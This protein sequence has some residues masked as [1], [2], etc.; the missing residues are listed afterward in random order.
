MSKAPTAGYSKNDITISRIAACVPHWVTYFYSRGIG[1][2]LVDVDLIEKFTGAKLPNFL[3]NKMIPSILPKIDGYE[4]ILTYCYVFSYMLDAIINPKNTATHDKVVNDIQTYVNAAFNST[5]IP[6]KMRVELMVNFGML[7]NN[8]KTHFN[9]QML[10]LGTGCSSMWRLICSSKDRK[11]AMATIQLRSSDQASIATSIE[12]QFEPQT[13]TLR[14]LDKTIENITHDHSPNI[15]R[16]VNLL[17]KK[18]KEI[19]FDEFIAA[20]DRKGSRNTMDYFMAKAGMELPE[21]SGAE[22]GQN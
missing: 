9:K 1:K 13:F 20:L 2:V 18:C 16:A 5:F 22:G 21:G 6:S 8:N 19:N 17:N 15:Q 10:S 14:F 12:D 3:K 7:E 11:D 4:D